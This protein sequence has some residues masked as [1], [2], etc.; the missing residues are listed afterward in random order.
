MFKR[1]RRAKPSH[2]IDRDAHTEQQ[3]QQNPID[4]FVIAAKELHTVRGGV[5][6]PVQIGCTNSCD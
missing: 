6:T 4:A 2:K 5:E 1:K 3:S